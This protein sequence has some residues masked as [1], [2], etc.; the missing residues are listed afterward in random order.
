MK[1][2][3]ECYIAVC[4]YFLFVQHYILK[5][6]LYCFLLS[7]FSSSQSVV[8]A[9]PGF[10]PRL[11]QG[12]CEIKTI[13]MIVQRCYLPFSLL[14]LV[15]I[16]M[17]TKQ[18]SGNCWHIIMKGSDP[19]RYGDLV[20]ILIQCHSRMSLITLLLEARP[21]LCIFLRRRASPKLKGSPR[22]LQPGGSGL[23]QLL[24][25]NPPWGCL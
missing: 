1:F 7:Q 3:Y 18:W 25:A 4:V 17:V 14:S 21:Y 24:P 22:G 8:C 20:V 15:M 5:I 13:S 12:I 16:S 23:W 2:L 10:F 9:L 6:H 19:T 11:V